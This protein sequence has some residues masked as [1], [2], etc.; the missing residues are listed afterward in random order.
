MLWWW[1]WRRYLKWSKHLWNESFLWY[2]CWVGGWRVASPKALFSANWLLRRPVGK[3]TPRESMFSWIVILPGAVLVGRW[4]QGS[5]WSRRPAPISTKNS[6]VWSMIWNAVKAYSWES[7]SKLRLILLFYCWNPTGRKSD[8]W[9]EE[10]NFFLLL[11]KW[12]ICWSLRI[13]LVWRKN[14]LKPDNWTKK[15]WW[16][17]WMVF[18][19]LWMSNIVRLPIPC[20]IC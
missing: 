15:K 1:N 13:P 7:G 11:R 5:L 12:N 20:L 17:M 19:T 8:V 18:S 3:Q 2:A 4:R 9:S 10:T 6:S 14:V 16:N